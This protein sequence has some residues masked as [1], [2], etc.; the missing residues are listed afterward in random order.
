MFVHL[1]VFLCVGVIIVSA[2]VFDASQQEG[3]IRTDETSF[4]MVQCVELSLGFI[5]T[6]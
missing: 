5:L 6:N 1:C 2:F 4:R 3:N